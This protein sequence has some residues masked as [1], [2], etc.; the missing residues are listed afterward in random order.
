MTVSGQRTQLVRELREREANA[1]KRLAEREEPAE[2]GGGGGACMVTTSPR[3]VVQE[4]SRV[5]TIN[6][7]PRQNAD[8]SRQWGT[9]GNGEKAEKEVEEEIEEVQGAGEIEGG[10]GQTGRRKAE[11]E[12]QRQGNGARAE[13][14]MRTAGGRA[15]RVEEGGKKSLEERQAG[16]RAVGDQ[17]EK[18][19]KGEEEQHVM[20]GGVEGECGWASTKQGEAAPDERRPEEEEEEQEETGAL[21]AERQRENEIKELRAEEERE[22]ARLIDVEMRRREV[23]E[24]LQRERRHLHELKEIEQTLRRVSSHSQCPG[25]QAA[26][27]VPELPMGPTFEA[28]ER[29]RMSE[30]HKLKE[31]KMMEE[32]KMRELSMLQNARKTENLVNNAAAIAPP[33]SSSSSSSP[34]PLNSE[35]K[36]VTSLPPLPPP[37]L[38]SQGWSIDV[39]APQ[40]NFHNPVPV[41]QNSD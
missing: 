35:G 37:K 41:S 28:A 29:Q 3:V 39:A 7:I 9:D 19:G 27:A 1:R 34:D 11:M 21:E 5:A 16:E 8:N 32:Q 31:L 2:D 18:A 40:L 26:A 6:A 22:T 30:L 24:E 13:Q 20:S 36:L 10:Q 38:K 12:Q 17:E 4:S 25:P 33:H 15:R 14:E 23:E